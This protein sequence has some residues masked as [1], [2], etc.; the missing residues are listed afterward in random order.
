VG[1][2]LRR[3]LFLKQNKMLRP[4]QKC[5]A[6]EIVVPNTTQKK[7]YFND[8]INLRN[9]V[10]TRI[11][12]IAPVSGGAL[13]PSGR[14]V[15][16]STVATNTFLTINDGQKEAINRLSLLH[17]NSETNYGNRFPVNTKINFR[18]SFI[19]FASL[20]GVVANTSILFLF[21]YEETLTPV[22]PIPE[23][24]LICEYIGVAVKNVYLDRHYFPNNDL[25]RGKKITKLLI[26]LNNLDIQGRTLVTSAVFKK[27]F[28]VLVV[29]GREVFFNMPLLLMQLSY[30]LDENDMVLNDMVIDWPKSYIQV[31][32]I[33][34]LVQNSVFP[35]HVF[36]N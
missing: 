33:T 21:C 14:S 4:V 7:L 10:I 19:E 15:I 26:D 12:V 11:D 20:T 2:G 6:V 31:A 36:F 1:R 30:Y 17:L 18:K 16:T 25:L 9:K 29:N 35:V 8:I 23:K 27:S 34:G 5:E 32:N 28:L 3:P 22:K 24:P 13:A